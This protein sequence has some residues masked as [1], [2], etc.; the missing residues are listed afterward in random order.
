[1]FKE[2]LDVIG[3]E[4]ITG[5]ES[6]L[7]AGSDRK[8]ER[9]LAGEKSFI[10]CYNRQVAENDT[11]LYFTEVFRAAS[12]PVPQ[13]LAVNTNRTEYLLSDNGRE[14]LLDQVLKYG[15][16]EE[17]KQWYRQALQGLVRLQVQAGKT[18]DYQRCVVA[19]QFD[20]QAVLFD[21]NY[22]KYYFLDLQKASYDRL[23]LQQE[24]ER[25]AASVEQIPVQH[26][27]YR[28]FQ[29]RNILVKDQ[30]ICFID[31]QGGMKGP[32]QYD[33]ASLLWQAKADLPQAWKNELFQFY[34][35]EMKQYLE[36]DD[37]RFAAD[38]SR[39]VLIRL[40]Q[41]LGAYG[42]RGL[43][44]KRGHFLSS[45]PQGLQNLSR[46]MNQYALSDYP[47]LLQVMQTLTTSLS[48]TTNMTTT[49]SAEA[50]L[51]INV[52][53][54]SYKKGI[55]EDRSGNGG[56]FVFDCRGLLNPGRFDD[57][58]KLTGRDQPVIDFLE[59][60]TR[61]GEFLSAAKQAVDISVEDYLARGFKN[62]QISFGCTGGQH[63]SVYC[64]DAMANYL[65]EKYHVKVELCHVEQE[66]KGWVN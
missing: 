46:W 10:L 35:A 2:A 20:R 64:A 30:T 61:I 26:F 17:V 32:V 55:P 48:T 43:I 19:R 50:T 9:I 56:G 27:M 58:K 38:Y 49:S 54:F 42:L 39:L 28:D 16:T 51:T 29:G 23:A 62:L 53:S 3:E 22:F 5:R 36:F 11:F 40:L 60:K 31:Y 47:V 14:S 8:Y 37:A 18:V 59:S 6:I 52:S 24:F 1:M 12:L 34:V 45:I 7:Q 65:Q 41:V 13:V 44:E 66:A 33:A 63:R 4:N 15:F 25:L 21:L 57:Y